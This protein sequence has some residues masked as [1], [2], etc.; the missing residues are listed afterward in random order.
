M[1]FTRRKTL[2]LGATGLAAVGAT[3]IMP[4]S[5]RAQESQGDSYDSENGKITISPIAH[6]SFVM[7]VPNMVIYVDPVGGAAAFE[8]NPP[9]DLILVTHEHGD[10]FEPDTLTALAGEQTQLV[11]NPS[12]FDKLPEALK[13][14]ATSIGN[15]EST[16]VGEIGIEAIPAYNTTPDRLQYHPKG[17]DNGYV[18]SADGRRVYIAGDT[19]DIPEMR[20]LSDIDIAFVPMNLPYTMDSD[21]AASAVAEF[22]PKVVYPYHYRGSDP[23]AF[24][25]KVAEAG[26]EIQVVQGPWYS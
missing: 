5:T 12:V 3:I 1:T 24:A 18:L 2:Q 9:A 23:E 7:T 13:S 20:A 8:G 11:T 16:T 15:G 6:A 17:R 25:A 4:F 10:H 14:K 22:A 26:A 19:E 21:Q